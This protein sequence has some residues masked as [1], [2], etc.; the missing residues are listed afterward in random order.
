MGRQDRGRKEREVLRETVAR[1]SDRK[2]RR[3]LTTQGW[4]EERKEPEEETRLPGRIECFRKVER[5]EE[6]CK[7]CCGGSHQRSFESGERH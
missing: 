2:G 1:L 7:G 6:S 3:K 5:G 4:K